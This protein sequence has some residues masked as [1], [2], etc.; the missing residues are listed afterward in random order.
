MNLLLSVLKTGWLTYCSASAAEDVGLYGKPMARNAQIWTHDFRLLLDG[1]NADQDH[2]AQAAMAL[3][4]GGSFGYRFQFPAMRV[5][6]YEIYWH[7]PLV[8]YLNAKTSQ[9]EIIFAAPLG[10]L[11]AYPA[12]RPDTTKPVALWPRLLRR[13]LYLSAFRNFSAIAN[14]HRHRITIQNIRKLLDAWELLAK[15]PLPSG[16][17]TSAF[18]RAQAGNSR[19][20]V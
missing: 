8:A 2:L 20:V 15:A 18:D 9:P 11:T 14:H 10:C 4:K 3:H 13:D 17:A 19:P 5:G 1:P 16:F 7:R 12:Q 6:E